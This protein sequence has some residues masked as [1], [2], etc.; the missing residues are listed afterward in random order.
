[1]RGRYVGTRGSILISTGQLTGRDCSL[2]TEAEK[3]RHYILE[4]RLVM[5]RALDR[6]LFGTESIHHINGIRGDNRI[7]NLKLFSC[8]KDHVQVHVI[9][10]PHCR[11]GK[12]VRP[13]RSLCTRCRIVDRRRAYHTKGLLKQT[14]A[15]RIAG[16]SRE[17]IR[18]LIV[19]GKLGAYYDGSMPS[20]KRNYLFVKQ[21][22]IEALTFRARRP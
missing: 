9:T 5:A 14:E 15:A 1:M 7:E 22:E 19:L 13:N 12:R 17:Y 10:W 20:R 3:E 18:Q 4:H 11:C 16:C 6:P 21:T 2:L 8:Q